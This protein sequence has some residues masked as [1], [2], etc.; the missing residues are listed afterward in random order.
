MKHGENVTACFDTRHWANERKNMRSGYVPRTSLHFTFEIT[1]PIVCLLRHNR[2]HRSKFHEKAAAPNIRAKRLNMHLIWYQTLHK[3]F[4]E[5]RE[6][7]L[8]PYQ[9][10]NYLNY[11]LQQPIRPGLLTKY[12]AFYCVRSCSTAFIQAN[13]PEPDDPSSHLTIPSL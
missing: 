4:T 13:H 9:Y 3:Y 1:C 12:P 10:L 2:L 11:Y 6:T 7:H 5:D 8:R